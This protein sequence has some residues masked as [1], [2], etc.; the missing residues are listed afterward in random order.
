MSSF[1]TNL[2][3]LH[4]NAINGN[5][6]TCNHANRGIYN[7]MFI[8]EIYF[9]LFTEAILFIINNVQVFG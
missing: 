5:Q 2:T 4:C 8:L 3:I 7:N 9:W 6:D 1:W